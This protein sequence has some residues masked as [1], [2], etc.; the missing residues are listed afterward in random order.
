[1]S[2]DQPTAVGTS[3]DV[4]VPEASAEDDI[5]IDEAVEMS[6]AV[7]A[8][9]AQWRGRPWLARL[10]RIAI[11]GVPFVLV[12]GLSWQINGALGTP[13]TVIEAVARWAA[14]SSSARCC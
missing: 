4:A 3:D 9:A 13:G 14:L 5:D 6:G 12:I 8:S 7:D 10:A 11:V 2:S 1:M